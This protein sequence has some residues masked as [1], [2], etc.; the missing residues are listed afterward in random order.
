MTKKQVWIAVGI[1]FTGLVIAS[2]YAHS[3]KDIDIIMNDPRKED[4]TAAIFDL[5]LSTANFLRFLGLA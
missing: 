1:L 3:K 5:L 4:K 2:Y